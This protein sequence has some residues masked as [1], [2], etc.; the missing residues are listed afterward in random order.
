MAKQ[1]EILTEEVTNG[2]ITKFK[3]G[4]LVS[5]IIKETDLSRTEVKNIIEDY[6]NTKLLSNDKRI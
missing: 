4:K 5:E 1:G 3:E 6:L 2:I